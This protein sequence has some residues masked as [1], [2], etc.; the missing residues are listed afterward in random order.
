MIR[1]G[2]T[3]PIQALVQ[4]GRLRNQRTFGAGQA[5]LSVSY[6]LTKQARDHIVLEQSDKPAEAWRN[7]RWDLFT[8]IDRDCAFGKERPRGLLVILARSSNAS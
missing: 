1:A 4:T 8:E 6:Y 5:G 2:A 7:H 3:S